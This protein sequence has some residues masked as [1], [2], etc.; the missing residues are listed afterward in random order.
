MTEEITNSETF[1]EEER[2]DTYHDPVRL[3]RIS[4][5]ANILSW[6][7]L[8]VVVLF[9]LFNLYGLIQQGAL[10]AG[11]AI[12]PSILSISFILLIGAF[13]FVVLQSI[14]E[15][16]YLFRDIEDNLRPKNEK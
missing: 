9:T 11:A 16:L 4:S 3:D 13:F 15:G 12:I 10:A 14:A 1:K 2:P 8:V 7:I 6:I 5:W